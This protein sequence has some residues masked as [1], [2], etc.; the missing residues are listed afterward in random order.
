MTNIPLGRV[1]VN[2]KN[3]APPRRNADEP[4][5]PARRARGPH[6]RAHAPAPLR[7][8]RSPPARSPPGAEPRGDRAPGLPAPG[9]RQARPQLL[10]RRHHRPQAPPERGGCHPG[11]L[12]PRRQGPRR[13]P[14]PALPAPA[15]G[16]GPGMSLV[17]DVPVER[18]ATTLAPLRGPR[19]DA[20]TS[21]APL[22]LRVAPAR[23]G[24]YEVLDG[25]KRLAH[26]RHA[27]HTHVPVVVEA[28]T[29]R[30]TVSPMDEARVVHSLTTDDHLSPI[31]I[32][33][34]LGHGRGWV[35][36]RLT[37]GHRLAPE[38]AGHLDDGRLSATTAT[39]LATLPHAEQKRLAQS[40]VRHGLGAREADAVLAAWRAA[41][42]TP[43]REALLRDPRTATPAPGE[44]AVCPL[45][46]TAR[47]LQARFLQTEQALEELTQLD[48]AGFT[49]AEQRVL[50]AGQRRLAALVIH[51]AHRFHKEPPN[52]ADSRGTA[53]APATPART[54]PDPRHCPTPE[55]RRQDHPPSAGALPQ[56][57]GSRGLEARPLPRADQGARAAGAALPADP[58]RD[59]GARVH[60]RQDDPQSLPAKPGPAP[61][62]AA[63]RLSPLRDPARGGSPVRLEPLP[64][65][66]RLPPDDRARLQP[67][68]LLLP[69][70]V[71]GLL[72]RRASADAALGPPG[73]LP[74][75]PGSL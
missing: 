16:G 5:A 35:D 44:P 53:R 41:P 54:H 2:G 18:L 57:S 60:G 64:R 33:K 10:V 70:A 31:Q 55:P 63:P 66:D 32:A 61:A 58:A 45:G 74:L 48:L 51:L 34:L 68:P 9:R 43:T 24:T 29:P 3:A 40:I 73:G 59:P 13:L 23:D 37:L 62:A 69:P 8:D 7:L 42:D 11:P 15:A 65:A 27:G 19:T 38:L 30:R 28:D 39:T 12:P 14:L 50:E 72:S 36:R 6:A 52:H 1:P 26:W 17:L 75:P 46:P 25:F 67:D 4:A 56:P 47:E 71:R 22:P 20:S 49:D 21:L